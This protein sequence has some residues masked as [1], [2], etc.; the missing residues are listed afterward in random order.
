[1]S[2]KYCLNCSYNLLQHRPVNR[3]CPWCPQGHNGHTQVQTQIQG[4]ASSSALVGS[5]SP[6]TQVSSGPPTPS[7]EPVL[8]GNCQHAK[9]YGRPIDPNCSLCL[10]YRPQ[11]QQETCTPPETAEDAGSGQCEGHSCPWAGPRHDLMC[12]SEPVF[13]LPVRQ[14]TSRQNIVPLSYFATKRLRETYEPRSHLP[15]AAGSSEGFHA[16]MRLRHIW[17]ADVSLRAHSLHMGPFG[18]RNETQRSLTPLSSS[19]G[20][21]PSRGR[22]RERRPAQAVA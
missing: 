10:Q 2:T 7:T 19:A 9:S 15:F 20:S 5:I 11:P 3:D 17:P 13:V 4:S 14:V 18:H 22:S 16:E 21:S 6:S 12:G 8:C 1:M